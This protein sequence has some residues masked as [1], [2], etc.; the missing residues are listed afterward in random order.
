MSD[1]IAASTSA[2]EP[3]QSTP[4]SDAK[5][6][7]TWDELDSMT[8]ESFNKARKEKSQSKEESEDVEETGSSV[9]GKGSKRETK[10]EKESED[11]LSKL[12]KEVEK[13]EQA[14]KLLKL[15]GKE[16]DIELASDTLVPVKIDGKVV[17]VPIQ[18]AINRYSQQSHLDKLYK[19]FK[20]EQTSYKKERESISEALNKSYDYLVNKKDLRGFLDMMGEAMGVDP[21]ELYQ[22]AVS[23]V[24]QQ[25]EEYQSLSPEEIR[26]R[27]MEA[28]NRYWKQKAEAQKQMESQA[29]SRKALESQVEQVMQQHGM[30]QA[31][32]VQAWDDLKALGHED[33][34]ITPEFLGAYYANT[35]TIKFIESK[36]TEVNPDLAQSDEIIEQLATYAIQT[37]ASREEVA[38]A[39]T[40]VYGDAAEKKLAKKINKNE[41]ANRQAGE[42]AV[43]NLGSDPLFFDDI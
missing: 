37:G 38:E 2:A 7:G 36:L 25:M 21:T 8:Q 29:K 18:E 42:K 11:K 30:D 15:K 4:V 31:A 5:S 40:Q 43:K 14:V 3:V 27:E 13:V 35:Q 6:P 41:R 39:I 23:K 28:E 1:T 12:E 22:D 33:S 16:G 34:S 26:L 9:E 19:T 17:E 32:L 20:E 10:G 24:R